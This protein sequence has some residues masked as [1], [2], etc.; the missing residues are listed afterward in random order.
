M[1]E[2]KEA[3]RKKRQALLAMIKD[4]DDA[5]SMSTISPSKLNMLK[6][7]VERDEEWYKKE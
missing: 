7:D 4:E 5:G 6:V 1:N 3:M 2:F